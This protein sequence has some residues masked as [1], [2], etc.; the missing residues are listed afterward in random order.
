VINAVLAIVFALLFTLSMR[1][2]PRR[3]RNGF[4]LV[5]AVLFALGTAL[6]IVGTTLVGGFFTFLLVF[7]LLP[8]S[9]LVLAVFLIVNALITT[10][11][12][13]LSRA[14]LF[15][16]AAGLA[17]LAV[18]FLSLLL[19]LS[20]NA[21]L[22]GLGVAIAFWASYLGSAFL[23]FLAW[24][25]AYANWPRRRQPAAIV[26]LGSGLIDGEVPP[27]L[28]GRLD[29]AIAQWRLHPAALLVP[30]GGQGDDEPRAEGEAM[31]EYLVAQGVPAE[32]VAAET[33]SRTTRENLVLSRQLLDERGISGDVLIVTSG[34]HAARAALLARELQI[35]GDAVGA[36]TAAY[37][38]PSAY[39]REFVAVLVEKPAVSI[40]FGLLGALAGIAFAS[41]RFLN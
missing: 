28:R 8:L 14:T 37:Y 4:L 29:A 15:S 13:G 34:Y 6:E 21:P 20:L 7:A 5:A 2:E 24:T 1:R 41:L 26:V 30:S 9:V 36:R 32:S 12:E 3:I 27:L 39:L 19:V 18:P 16:G 40:V 11:R 31:R 22:Q 10:R 38:V 35:T 17:L 23:V 33:A 25:I